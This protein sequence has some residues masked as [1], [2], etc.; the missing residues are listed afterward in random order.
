MAVHIIIIVNAFFIN[1]NNNNNND[2]NNNNNHIYTDGLV[3][4]YIIQV[5]FSLCMT[6]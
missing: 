2:N 3:N 5:K 6:A 4:N 1:N